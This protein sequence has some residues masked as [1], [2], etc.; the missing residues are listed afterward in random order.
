MCL[1]SAVLLGDARDCWWHRGHKTC[2]YRCK[3]CKLTPSFLSC[4]SFLWPGKPSQHTDRR[5]FLVWWRLAS[6][7]LRY[8]NRHLEQK[9]KRKQT[10][11]NCFRLNHELKWN[12]WE[13]RRN[14]LIMATPGSESHGKVKALWE[15]QWDFFLIYYCW[16]VLFLGQNDLCCSADC[17]Q[18]EEENLGSHENF[19]NKDC[20]YLGE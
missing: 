1:E 6:R 14:C 19:L 4:L 9:L 18:V 5:S 7:A 11:G 8:A 13:G 16:I 17:T 10:V 20:N 3:G 12:S 2:D 15:R